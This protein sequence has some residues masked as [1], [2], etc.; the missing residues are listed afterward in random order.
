MT[1]V[2]NQLCCN[3]DLLVQGGTL[4]SK[5]LA[6]IALRHAQL[7]PRAEDPPHC[8]VAVWGIFFLCPKGDLLLVKLLQGQEGHP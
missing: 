3:A 5:H 2:S 1:T 7:W 8:W 4:N 6:P